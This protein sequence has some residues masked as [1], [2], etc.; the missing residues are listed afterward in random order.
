MAK[1]KSASR[2]TPSEEVAE[3]PDEVLTEQTAE[4]GITYAE[5]RI[6]DLEEV[7]QAV[8]S[9]VEFMAV[10]GAINGERLHIARNRNYLKQFEQP[11]PNP[12]GDQNGIGN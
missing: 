10:D 11:E 1:K 7:Q 9:P 12:R 6:T 8:T 2:G 3:L 5:N 4:A